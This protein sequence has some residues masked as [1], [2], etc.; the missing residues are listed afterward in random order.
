MLHDLR[1]LNLLAISC[2]LHLG[3]GVFAKKVIKSG[4]FV[5]QYFGELLSEEEGDLRESCTPSCFRYF[6]KHKAVNYW[7]VFVMHS[8]D[9]EVPRESILTYVAAGLFVCLYVLVTHVHCAK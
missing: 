3:R 8:T 5:V 4:E 7:L 1:Y 9:L 6:F 2:C